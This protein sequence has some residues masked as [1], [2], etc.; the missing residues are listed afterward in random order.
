[1]K[2]AIPC[3]DHLGHYHPCR[4]CKAETRPPTEGELA[5][6]RAIVEAAR[7]HTAEQQREAQARMEKKR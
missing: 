2:N 6:L 1:M 7:K 4:R 5:N 3:P